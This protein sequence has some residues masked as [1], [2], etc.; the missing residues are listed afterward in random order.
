MKNLVVIRHAK[1]DWNEPAT[2]DIDRPLNPR[3]QR[4][5]PF[6]GSLL[7]FRGLS[8]DLIVS[9]PAKRALKTARL[10]AEQVGYEPD[11]IEIRGSIYLG[12]VSVLIELIRGLDDA[13]GRVYLIGH[14]PDLTDLVN[15]LAGEDIANLPTCG[16][17]SLTFEVE[18]WGHIM[19][20]A[21]RLVFFDYPKRH[22]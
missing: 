10:I 3:G 1:S 5:A 2:A 19:E 12:S 9:S 6:M 21:G 7:K 20:G 4:D 15:R 22:R 11:A 18:S 16:I 17:A 14:N 13:L 8:P